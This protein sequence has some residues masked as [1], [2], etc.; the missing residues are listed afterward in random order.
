MFAAIQAAH[1][2]HGKAG[3]STGEPSDLHVASLE[4]EVVDRRGVDR[5]SPRVRA[6]EDASCYHVWVPAKSMKRV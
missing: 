5:R 3:L 6:G 1:R 2:N 4:V